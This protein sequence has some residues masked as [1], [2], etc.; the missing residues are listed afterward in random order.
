[1]GGG[2]TWPRRRQREVGPADVPFPCK[3]RSGSVDL[4][5]RLS[6]RLDF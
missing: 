5:S 6:E 1:M 4:L 2:W 3:S